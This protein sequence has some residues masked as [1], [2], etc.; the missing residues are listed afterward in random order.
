MSSKIE[1]VVGAYH[2][3][4]WWF[5]GLLWALVN[6]N[7]K[8][9]SFQAYRVFQIPCIFLKAY[10]LLLVDRFSKLVTHLFPNASQMLPNFVIF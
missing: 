8:Y 3:H 7:S 10:I 2:T 5:V 6:T 4:T 1:R 9:S